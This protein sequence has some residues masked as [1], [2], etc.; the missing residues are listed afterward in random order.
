MQP[1]VEL[2]KIRDLGELV[3][4]SILFLKQNWRPLFKTYFIICGF[5]WVA[6]MIISVLNQTQSFR[7]QG[8]G[9]SVYSL[10]YFLSVLFTFINITFLMLTA[11][12]FVALYK[13]KG[14]Q[15]PNVEEVWSYVK[16]YIARAFASSLLLILM[17]AAGT[18]FCVIPGIYLL[19]V[20]L[21]ILTIIVL[22]NAS[23]SYAF[24][25]AFRIIKNNWW[26]LFSTLLIIGFLVCSTMVLLTIPVALIVTAML[27][28][29]NVNHQH[30]ISIAIALTLTALQF[31]YL[32]P[33]V[34]VAISYY[35][36]NL[37][38]DDNSLLQRIEMIGKDDKASHDLS[39]EE[40]Y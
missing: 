8:Y 15:A 31:L 20:A 33:T 11:L 25:L 38:N 24:N 4:D 34:A 3:D 7:L 17:V 16:Y 32:L 13:E 30:T 2:N 1:K 22:E 28:L 14:N 40:E 39:L 12:S 19:P 9:E 37:R 29:T 6:G 36:L 23:L 35:N 27:Y 21:L 18:L 10:T 26:S 5:F